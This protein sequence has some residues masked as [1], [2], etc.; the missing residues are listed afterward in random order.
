MVNKESEKVFRCYYESPIGLL[1]L[2]ASPFQL[3]Y[4]Q[5]VEDRK[6]QE[7]IN[8]VLQKTI[9]QLDDYFSGKRIKFDLPL[10]VVGTDFQNKVWDALRKINY[11]QTV[12]YKIIAEKINHSKAYRAVG[13]ANNKNQLPIIIPCH[14]VIGS[15]GRLTGYAGGLWRKQWLLEH[16]KIVLERKGK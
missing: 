16:E 11:G 2:L 12:T 4:I 15:K 5:F 8:E 7:V 3:E 6:H 10:N 14:R 9:L 13:H 1:L